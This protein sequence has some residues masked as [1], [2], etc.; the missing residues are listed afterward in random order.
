MTTLTATGGDEMPLAVNSLT[1]SS[2]M[3]EITDAISAS[4]ETCMNE[5]TPSGMSRS[6][7]S[8]Q[9]K[10]IAY[11][12]ARKKTGKELGRKGQ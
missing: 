11:D 5:P 12:V 6:E 4:I 1:T 8:A 10:A 2:S 9:C 3:D 7:R